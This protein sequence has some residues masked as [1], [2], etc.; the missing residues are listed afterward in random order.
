M[1]ETGSDQRAHA[2]AGQPLD[3]GL[4]NKK[5]QNEPVEGPQA[6]HGTNFAKTFGDRHQLGIYD[7]DHT[8][9]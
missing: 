3:P 7:P 9:Q 1:V 2:G 8:D 4:E 6:F 5:A